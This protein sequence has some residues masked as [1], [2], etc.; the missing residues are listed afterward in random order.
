MKLKILFV[1]SILIISL[2]LLSGCSETLTC[3]TVTKEVKGCDKIKGCTCIHESLFG[4][5]GCD[6]CTCQEGPLC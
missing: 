2:L 3:K 1:M 5:G 4:L 6:T